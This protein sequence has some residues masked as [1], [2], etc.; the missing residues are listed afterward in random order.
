M[1]DRNRLTRDG[2]PLH[3]RGIIEP[4]QE[5]DLGD[6]DPDPPVDETDDG[7]A[8]VLRQPPPGFEEA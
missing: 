2:E 8:P 1:K 6:L 3:D 5:D 4:Q 7:P